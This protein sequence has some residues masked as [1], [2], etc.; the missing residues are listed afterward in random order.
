MVFFPSFTFFY[1]NLGSKSAKMET[2]KKQKNFLKSGLLG[3]FIFGISILGI[4]QNTLIKKTTTRVKISKTVHPNQN[5]VTPIKSNNH[6]NYSIPKTAPNQ[7]YCFTD[8]LMDAYLK[9]NHLRAQFDA[10][11][12]QMTQEAN[13]S[14]THARQHYV[15]PVVFHVVYNT[16]TQNV[17]TATI[18]SIFNEL[19]DDYQ[20]QNSDASDARSQYGF[21]PA[22]VDV[23]FCLAVRDPQNNPLAQAGID[24]HHTNTTYF[25]PNNNP[26]DMKYTSSGGV[27]SWD[28]SHYLN[29]WICNISNGANSGVAGYSYS[30]TT[31]ALPPAAIDGVV[32]DYHLATY[33]GSRALTHEVGHYLGLAHTWGNSNQSTSCSGAGDGINDTPMTQG[34]SFNYA[35]SCSGFQE[36][37]SGTQTQY[38]NYMDYSNCTVM[39]TADQAALMQSILA[40]SRSSMANSN[41]C[42]PLNNQ[43]P[44]ADF[45]A[46]IT[47]VVSGGTV[48]FTDQSTNYPNAWSW[49]I[50]PSSG[51]NYTGSTSAS[52]QNPK[53]IFTTPG[54]YTVALTATN[55]NGSD[56]K[57]R[58]SYITVVASG[59]GSVV[60]D[61]VNNFTAAEEQNMTAF[62]INGESGYY[63][64]HFTLNSGA[65]NVSKIAEMMHTST[66]SQLRGIYFPV[67]IINDMGASNSISFKIYDDNNG[68]PGTVLATE[69]KWLGSLQ[70]QQWN[71]IGFSSPATVNGDFW[72]SFEWTNTA[73]F[74]TLAFA[75]TNP[76]DRPLINPSTAHSSTSVYLGGSYGWKHTS[77]ILGTSSTQAYDVSMIV[78]ALL[79]N[80]PDPHAVLSISANEAC[81]NSTIDV[82]GFGSTNTTDYNWE[83]I[84][85]STT[86]VGQGGDI[87]FNNLPTGTWNVKLHAMGSCSEDIATST[88]VIDPSITDNIIKTDENCNKGD[89][90]ITVSTI[91]GGSGS[92]YSV[93]INNGVNFSSS[94][95]FTFNNLS[96][97]SYVTIVKDN[98]CADT[99]TVL[100]SNVDNFNPTLTPGTAVSVNSG[101]QVTLSVTGGSSWV[102][103]KQGE[104]APFSTSSSITVNPTETTIYTVEATDSNGCSKTFTI[105]VTVTGNSGVN[106]EQLQHKIQIYPNPFQGQFKLSASFDKTQTIKVEVYDLLG[107][108]ISTKSFDKINKLETNIDLSNKGNGAYIVRVTGEF[109]TYT[110]RVIKMK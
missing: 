90:S 33:V 37:C 40:S 10:Q 38:E 12:Q 79:S 94:A 26:N 72:V 17:S 61:T 80:G 84:Q 108:I 1:V 22:N 44:A 16:S 110:R 6:Y 77:D 41:A 31:S 60:C 69:N 42:T 104:T 45:V 19:N 5:S 103:Y 14:Q 96:A 62:G 66:S 74:D 43:P 88:L 8:Q 85:G 13:A 59:G 102:W 58:N 50:T 92:N 56:T 49:S 109:G 4:S 21:T 47:T 68:V 107:E 91:S 70:Q 27:A 25:D 89:G 106:D 57:T 86:Y 20:L 23:S 75:T 55:S 78:D 9:A 87:S 100:L 39:F 76:N 11:Y 64:G 2:M 3:L 67:Y 93:S 30:P 52:S 97:G 98:F 18:M 54:T 99:S 29:V 63:P 105:T 28:R 51:W 7:G 36:T 48:N 24:R 53:V 82:N 81:E 83:F 71:Y 15:I 32:L 73:P 35:G 34:P 95:P 65:I 46:D 101:D